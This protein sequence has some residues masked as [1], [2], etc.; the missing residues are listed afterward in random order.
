MSRCVNA[1]VRVLAFLGED[2]VRGCLLLYQS[3]CDRM[4]M[5]RATGSMCATLLD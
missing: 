5:V 3:S 2:L 4:R 1:R